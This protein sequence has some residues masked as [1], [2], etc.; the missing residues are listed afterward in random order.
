MRGEGEFRPQTL[1]QRDG[2]RIGKSAGQQR[3]EGGAR[4]AGGAGAVV[5]PR[6]SGVAFSGSLMALA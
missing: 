3:F 4:G 2:N 1:R 6:L 5:Q